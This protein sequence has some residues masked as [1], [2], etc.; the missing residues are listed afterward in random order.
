MEILGIIMLV[1]TL[2]NTVQLFTKNNDVISVFALIGL[3][4]FAIIGI[5]H[6]FF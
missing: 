2:I 1:I 5:V 6:T 4:S 3:L